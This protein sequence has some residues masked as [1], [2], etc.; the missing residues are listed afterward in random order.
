M[1]KIT[2]KTFL[3]IFRLNLLLN[4]K[5]EEKLILTMKSIK[6]FYFQSSYIMH[7]HVIHVRLID[8]GCIV[9]SNTER[10]RMNERDRMN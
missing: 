9:H 5:K 2:F 6:I 4:I 7:V 10:E 3:L 8:D 1:K